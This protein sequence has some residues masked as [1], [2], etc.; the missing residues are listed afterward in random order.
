MVEVIFDF[1]FFFFFKSPRLCDRFAKELSNDFCLNALQRK[2]DQVIHTQAE[3]HVCVHEK[4]KQESHTGLELDACAS[5]KWPYKKTV[6]ATAQTLAT[7][8]V[9]YLLSNKC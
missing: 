8:A 3:K 1:F 4:Q 7:Y 6:A 5:S 2:T 9:K